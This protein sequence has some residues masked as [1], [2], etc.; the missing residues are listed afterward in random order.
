MIKLLGQRWLIPIWS[1]TRYSLL[2]TC[3]NISIGGPYGC[4]HSTVQRLGL[5]PRSPIASP[6]PNHYVPLAAPCIVT[7]L[8]YNCYIICYCLPYYSGVAR[9]TKA[10]LSELLLLCSP[11]FTNAKFCIN[12]DYKISTRI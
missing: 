2:K 1:T 4:M 7:F 6:A 3:K 9:G 11:F 8:Y 5:N 12:C 10:I